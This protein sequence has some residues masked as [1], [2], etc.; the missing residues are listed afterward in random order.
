VPVGLMDETEGD[1]HGLSWN[2]GGSG[3][4]EGGLDLGAGV[5]GKERGEAKGEQG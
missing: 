5:G 1:L 2:D 3:G 4:N